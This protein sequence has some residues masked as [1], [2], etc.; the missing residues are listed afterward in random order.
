M[1]CTSRMPRMCTLHAAHWRSEPPSA[2]LHA[3]QHICHHLQL[4]QYATTQCHHQNVAGRTV[5]KIIAISIVE[6][7]KKCTG[8]A[9]FIFATISTHFLKPQC[10]TQTLRH[11]A[12]LKITISW[13]IPSVSQTCSPLHPSFLTW[14]MPNLKPR[15][16]ENMYSRRILQWKYFTYTRPVTLIGEIR[17]EDFCYFDGKLK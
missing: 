14:A 15:V 1:P 5:W 9:V 7:Y 13:E 16:F 3:T 8:I 12:I 17:S 2:D 4:A 10:I 6:K 11:F